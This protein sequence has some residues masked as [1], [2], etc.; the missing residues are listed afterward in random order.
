MRERERET[1]TER[2]RDRESTPTGS[3]ARGGIQGEGEAD[4]LPSREPNR[5]LNSSDTVWECK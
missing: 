1:E 5:G 4:T 3:S 2:E